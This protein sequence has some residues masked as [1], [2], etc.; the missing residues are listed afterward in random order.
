MIDRISTLVAEQFPQFYETDGQNFIAFVKAYYEF[1]EERGGAI[2]EVK[3]LEDYKN[4]ETTTDDFVKYFINTFLPQ[5]P[6]DVAGDKRLM[7]KYA[8]QFNQARGTI[9]SYKLL[10]RVLYNENVD[11]SMPSEK[12]LKVSD[13]DW[14]IERYITTQYKSELYD[15][16]GKTIKGES[17]SAEALVEDIVRKNVRGRDIM[18][19][20]LSNIKG[21]FQNLEAI[22]ISNTNVT[23]AHI[24][25]G[26]SNIKIKSPGGGYN[27]G[28]VVDLV[29]SENGEFGKVVVVE[30]KDYEGALEYSIIDG[31]SGYTSSGTQI[32]FHGGDGIDSG[33]F[34]INNNNIIDTFALAI[35]TTII[36]ANNVFGVNAPTIDSVRID[37]FAKMPLYAP[38]FGIRKSFDA[39]GDVPYYDQNDALLHVRNRGTEPLPVVGDLLLGVDT[40]SR[41]LV[42]RIVRVASSQPL[43]GITQRDFYLKIDGFG[44]FEDGEPVNVGETRVGEV[45]QN[46]SFGGGIISSGFTSNTVGRRIISLSKSTINSRT[47]NLGDTITTSTS[48]GVVKKIIEQTPTNARVLLAASDSANVTSNFGTGP[49]PNFIRDEDYRV[50]GFAPVAGVIT[51]DASNNHVE[52]LYSPLSDI[53]NHQ[54]SSFGSI[55]SLTLPVGGSGY[56]IPPRISVQDLDVAALGI[57]EYTITVG[58]G[59]SVYNIDTNDAISQSSTGARADVK[60]VVSRTPTSTTLR[61]WQRPLQRTNEN[62][63]LETGNCFIEQHTSEYVPGTTDTRTPSSV[64]PSTITSVNFRGILGDNADISAAVGLNGSISKLRVIDSGFSY[65]NKEIVVIQALNDGSNA[66]VEIGLNDVANA[67][68]YYTSSRGH[69]G[70]NQGFIQDNKYYQEFSYEVSS[71]I[72]LSRYRDVVLNL[73]H[74]AGQALFGKIRTESFVPINITSDSNIDLQQM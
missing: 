66:T 7:I 59:S 54:T 46:T 41:G 39:A 70:S 3:T 2:H 55:G 47:I 17:S 24:E 29:S 10:F 60:E 18:Q 62:I 38:D 13:G 73:V 48:S 1:M 32:T 67:E 43:G 23:L 4:V 16:I 64:N 6:Y 57:A 69:I 11:I 65:K 56:T 25:A 15:V 71:P 40:G 26:I 52:N 42:K 35:D 37:T 50:S 45:A 9:A 72:S 22:K 68:G 21:Q 20:L 31:G 51:N 30:T 19:I 44:R 33:S 58:I 63:I 8:S 12:I 74:P 27:T 53:I 5:V 28:D 14:K 61:V 36:G 34:Q 49:M